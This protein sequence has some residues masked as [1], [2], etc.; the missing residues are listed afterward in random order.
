MV[1]TKHTLSSCLQGESV[2]VFRIK[3]RTIWEVNRMSKYE[4]V[5]T[6]MNFV[7]REK[8]VEKFWKENQIFEKSLDSHKEG[9]TY[10]F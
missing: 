10:T 8:A 4:K 1:E 2:F 9:E 3:C 6:D 5:S 7:D